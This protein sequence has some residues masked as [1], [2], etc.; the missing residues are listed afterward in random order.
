MEWLMTAMIPQ[1]TKNNGA[2]VN[3]VTKSAGKPNVKRKIESKYAP[4]SSGP[5][6]RLIGPD[7]RVAIKRVTPVI[8]T[9]L[10]VN[11]TLSIPIIIP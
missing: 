9:N 1:K 11:N 5:L 8:S 4:N 2:F 7:N 6:T 10:F 3:T